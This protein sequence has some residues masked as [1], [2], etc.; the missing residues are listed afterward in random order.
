[1]AQSTGPYVVEVADIRFEIYKLPF[2]TRLTLDRK[3][4]SM[5]LPVLSGLDGMDLGKLEEAISA[6]DKSEAE[7]NKLEE[8]I[9]EDLSISKLVSALTKA[10]MTLSD[11]DWQSLA[12]QLL[13]VVNCTNSPGNPPLLLNNEANMDRAF[14]DFSTVDVYRVCIEVMRANKFAPFALTGAGGGKSLGTV[15]SNVVKKSK[16]RSGVRLAPSESSTPSQK[17]SGLSGEQ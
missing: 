13:S 9:S 11:A 14:A 2:L 4:G 8:E 3:V 16:K 6:G 15:F 17:Q 5:I 1:M 7:I 10:L 12:K